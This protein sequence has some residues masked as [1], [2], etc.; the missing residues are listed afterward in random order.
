MRS[1]P[2]Q[3]LGTL[4]CLLYLGQA[5]IVPAFHLVWHSAE[6][7]SGTSCEKCRG[8]KQGELGFDSICTGSCS[9]PEHHHHQQKPPHDS[10]SCR[11]CSSKQASGLYKSTSL[12]PVF[13]EATIVGGIV[14]VSPHAILQDNS[15]P[16]APP[17]L[18]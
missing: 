15:S 5:T 7:S 1:R 12:C 11:V 16:R 4:I 13:D 8:Q 14:E 10:D 2:F 6:A 3:Y 9:D 17:F 18:L